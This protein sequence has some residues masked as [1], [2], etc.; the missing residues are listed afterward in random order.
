M[1]RPFALL[2]GLAAGGAVVAADGDTLLDV[3]A[4][5]LEN[6]PRVNIAR[7][8][9]EA[10]E[11]GRQVARGGLLPQATASGQLTDNQIEFPEAQEPGRT[12]PGERYSVQVRQML[13]DWQRISATR[14]ANR[15]V[16]QR[17]SELLDALGQLSVDVGQRYFDVLLADRNV[18]LL[19]AE[20]AL[21]EEEAASTRAL[22]ERKLAR[23]TDLL[24]TRA[25][26][27]TVRSE[28]IRA[29]NEAALA[30]EELMVLTGAPIN[31]LAG[32]REDADL[33]ALDGPVTRW[34]DLAMAENALLQSKSDAVQV[35]RMGVEEQRGG[36]LP[37][38]ELVASY[39]QSDV[40]FDNL[41]TQEREIEYLGV[42]VSIPLFRG[43]A[44]RGR[45]REAWAQYYISREEE[46]SVRREVRKRVRGAWLTANAALRRV[47][48]A[49]L[50]VES[51]ET[52]YEAMRKARS[53]G[54]ATSTAVLEALH[55]QTRALRDYWQAVY[56]YLYNWL[57]LHREAGLLDADTLQV[58]DARLEQ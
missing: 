46:E 14:R 25:R 24:E 28:I 35:A 8:R 15:L 11:A 23:R 55:N 56:E 49:T 58:L 18:A 22:Y 32:V 20:K 39:Q 47:D 1:L 16:D 33:P 45:I 6:D 7:H 50:S 13:F 4:L 3:Y 12:Y 40:G 26:V 52:S 21:A 43:G 9:V 29:E 2:L 57:A 42:E 36:F 44:S 48:A 41:Q 37:T 17:T 19:E 5:A 27:D 53:L 38:A 51:A 54:S 31:A 30:R 34:V 10:G